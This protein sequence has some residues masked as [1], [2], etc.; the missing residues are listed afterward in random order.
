MTELPHIFPHEFEFA[1]RP[2]CKA[3]CPLASFHDC[4]EPRCG[5]AILERIP[6]RKCRLQLTDNQP[7]EAWGLKAH[8]TPHFLLVLVYH[9]LVFVST[10]AFWAWWLFVHPDDLQNASVPFMAA[11]AIVSMFWSSVATLKALR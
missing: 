11:V 5:N 7:E 9:C 6:K 1:L 10:F 3:A 2:P 4:V 8:Y